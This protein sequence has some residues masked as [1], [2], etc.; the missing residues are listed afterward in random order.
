[1]SNDKVVP[2]KLVVN[3]TEDEDAINIE[4][5]KCDLLLENALCNLS[6]VLIIGR[7]NNDSPYVTSTSGDKAKLL[8]MVEQF[9]HHLLEGLYDEE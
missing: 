8:L 5:T 2:F 9:K 1:M 3:N 6:E 7:T 4:A